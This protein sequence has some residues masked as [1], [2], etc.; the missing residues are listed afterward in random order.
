MMQ[1]VEQDGS[2]RSGKRR[3]EER[4]EQ[5][6]GNRSKLEQNY[7]EFRTNATA[8]R[9]TAASTFDVHGVKR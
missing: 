1:K 9:K 7:E 5:D 3:N 6:A 4:V 2:V 8:D